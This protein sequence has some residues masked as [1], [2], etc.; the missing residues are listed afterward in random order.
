MP[1]GLAGL[2]GANNNRPNKSH[3]ES[4]N[5]QHTQRENYEGQPF[6]NEVF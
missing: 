1:N 2:Y 6:G 5:S 3:D 4:P